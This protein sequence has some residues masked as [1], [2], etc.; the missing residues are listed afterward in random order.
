MEVSCSAAFSH[1]NSFLQPQAT[2]ID[3]SGEEEIFF[4][5]GL[6]ERANSLGR[7]VIE[8][9]ENAEQT[10]MWTTL[11]DSASLSGMLF[12]SWR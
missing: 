11:L 5:K 8:L 12:T 9:P 10:L 1:I 6:K 4:M 2:F 3:S 7:T